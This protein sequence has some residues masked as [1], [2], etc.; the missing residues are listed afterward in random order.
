MINKIYRRIKPDVGNSNKSHR[1]S[2]LQETLAAIPARARI[3][4]AGAGTQRYKKYC[5]HLDYVSQ[6]FASYDGTGDGSGIQM[7]NFDYG[8]LDIVSDISAIPEENCSFD[9]IM[10]IEVLEHLPDPLPAIREFSRLLKKDGVL[11]LSAPFCSL[12]HFAPYHFSSGFNRYWYNKHLPD[13]GFAIERMSTNGNYFEYLAQELN[14]LPTV[15]KKYANSSIGFVTRIA[16]DVLL[17]SLKKNSRVDAGS[18]SLLCYGYE[19]IAH[20]T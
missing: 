8:E 17:R 7:G 19:I 13:N 14:R 16:L 5:K 18:S 12:T 11:L 9:A 4:D 20:K 6:D 10:C 2:W 3:L 15:S 1:V